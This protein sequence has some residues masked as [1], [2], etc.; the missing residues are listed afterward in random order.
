MRDQKT[1]LTEHYQGTSVS[2]TGVGNLFIKL[3]FDQ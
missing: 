3:H 1:L 2:A